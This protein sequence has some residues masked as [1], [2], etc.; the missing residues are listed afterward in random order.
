MQNMMV[1]ELSLAFVKQ[2][3]NLKEKMHLAWFY[4]YDGL[5]G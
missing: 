4:N 2:I 3:K 1:V 5:S